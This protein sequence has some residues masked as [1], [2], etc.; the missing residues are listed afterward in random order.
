MHNQS[1]LIF[2][3][4]FSFI[5]SNTQ[6]LFFDGDD[7]ITVGDDSSLDLTTQ[8]T[9]SAWI[10]PST[11]TQETYA[12]I[13]AKSH[14]G[15]LGGDYEGLSY[16]LVW[17][18]GSNVIR[19]QISDGTSKSN[20]SM[21]LL[22]D[23]NW[24]HIAFTWDGSNLKI[25]LDGNLQSVTS[26][27]ISGAQATNYDLKIGG[28]AFGSD[29]GSNDDFKGNIDEVQI[30]NRALT[31]SEIID[32]M[33]VPSD[34]NENGLVGNWKFDYYDGYNPNLVYDY[35]QVNDGTKTGATYSNDTPCAV[36]N[37][38]DTGD[39]C[40]SLNVCQT[41]NWDYCINNDC[42]EGDG[43]CDGGQCPSGFTCGTDNCNYGNGIDSS[44]DCCICIDA[45]NNGFCDI[46]EDNCSSHSDC[47]EGQFC[48]YFGIC[49][50]LD[51]E[52]CHNNTCYEG[53]GDCDD[54][55]VGGTDSV[56]CADG[57]TCGIDNCDFGSDYSEYD[58]CCLDSNN[59]DICDEIECSSGFI[60]DGSSCSD[61]NECSNN[62]HN[63]SN[64][65]NC[66]NTSGSYQCQ[67]INECN[68]G[69][70][71]CGAN[72]F[73]TNT[74]GGFN[75]SCDPGY[76]GDGLSCHD[77][78]ECTD[79]NGND[80][81][82]CSNGYECANTS[83]SYACLD[84]NECENSPCGENYSCTNLDGSY[85][86]NYVG[87]G[88][89]DNE[90]PSTSDDCNNIC[91]ENDS[92]DGSDCDDICDIND[93]GSGPDC[94]GICE[95][96]DIAGSI[97]CDGICDN[98]SSSSVDCCEGNQYS[99][100]GES[101]C[102]TCGYG[103][104]TNYNNTFCFTCSA[105]YACD[106]VNMEIC[107]AG[108]FSDSGAM[109][110]TN[111]GSANKYSSEGSDSCLTCAAGNYTNWETAGTTTATECNEC[112]H[113]YNCPGDGYNYDCAGIIN[114]DGLYD[115]NNICCASGIFDCVGVCDGDESSN[116]NP[117]ITLIGDTV[118]E[119][120]VGELD[121][122][123]DPGALCNDSWDGDLTNTVTV[124][125]DIVNMNVADV[126]FVDYTCIDGCGGETNA[127]RVV[128]ITECDYS[129]DIDCDGI[130]NLLDLCFGNNAYGDTD[131]DGDCNDID[132]DDD[133]DGIDDSNDICLGQIN[134]DFDSDGICDDIDSDIDNDNVVNEIDICLG[135][136]LLGDMDNDGECDDIDEDDDGDGILDAQDNCT[137]DYS[138]CDSDGDGILDV[139]DPCYGN[140][141]DADFDQDGYCND[142]D[143]DDD[144]DTITDD[145]DIC[146]GYPNEDLDSDGICDSQDNDSDGDGVLDVDDICLGN[147][148][149]DF[150]QDGICD[151]IDDDDDD[152]NIL[153]EN[154]NCLG[155][156][157]LSIDYN[158]ICTVNCIQT[159][160]LLDHQFSEHY[161]I[162][163]D[164]ICN[165]LDTD[166][167]ND[168]LIDFQENTIV[169]DNGEIL[170]VFDEC[171]GNYEINYNQ[172]NQKIYNFEKGLT[173]NTNTWHNVDFDNDLICND[174]DFDSDNDGSEDPPYWGGNGWDDC[175]GTWDAAYTQETINQF[176]M[177][178]YHLNDI[179]DDG[180]CNDADNDDDNDGLIDFDYT[181]YQDPYNDKPDGT[182][183]TTSIGGFGFSPGVFYDNCLHLYIPGSGY[184]YEFPDLYVDFDNDGICDTWDIDS[185]G[186][187][188]IDEGGNF[189]N[190]SCFDLCLG[191]NNTLDYD[192][193]GLC[194]DT[195][196]DDDNDG[197]I[198]QNDS[199]ICGDDDTND[200]DSDGL[201]DN[202]DLDD[203][204]DGILDT[205]DSCLGFSNEDS[206]NDGIC[207]EEDNDSDGDGIPNNEDNCIGSPNVDFDEDGICDNIDDDDDNDGILDNQDLC[208]GDSS[209]SL[210]IYC[211]EN[212]G[213]LGNYLKE[214]DERQT[215]YLG[216]SY[217]Y[218]DG[219]VYRY[220]IDGD[221][222]CNDLDPDDDGDGLIDFE[223]NII[224]AE[225]QN[226]PPTG[227][228][229]SV[230]DKC[231]GNINNNF[232]A[233]IPHQTLCS[234][235]N[236]SDGGYLWSNV[237]F[238]ADGLCNDVDDDSDDDGVSDEN[239]DC[240][241]DNWASTQGY[242]SNTVLGLY[243]NQMSGAYYP[244]PDVDYDGLCNDLD[245]DNDNDGLI[246]FEENF[247]IDY[248]DLAS[249]CQHCDINNP[250][251]YFYLNCS[252]GICQQDLSLPSGV[253]GTYI[254]GCLNSP[255]TSADL[256]FNNLNPN[257]YSFFHDTNIDYDSDGVC[258]ID[259][260]DADGDEI[261]DYGDECFGDNSFFDYDFDDLC[262]DF[263]DDDDNDGILD[264]DDNIICGNSSDEAF[265]FDSDGVCDNWDLDDDDD[266]IFDTADSC[267]GFSN[268]D[269]DN[270]GICDDLDYNPSIISIEDIP[271]DQGGRV[272]VTFSSSSAD[273]ESLT[274]R[275]VEFYTIERLDSDSNDN[276][277]WVSVGTTSAYNQEQYVVEVTTLLNTIINQDGQVL[278]DGNTGFRVIASMEEG[279]FASDTGYGHSI[280]NIAPATPTNF[281]SN[282]E[283]G[284]I[285]LNWDE[286]VDNDFL[287]FDIYRN[288]EFLLSTTK[289]DIVDDALE[290]S[291]L[292]NYTVKSVDI[293]LNESDVSNNLQITTTG[294][295]DVNY[296]GNINVADVIEIV[297][298]II[299]QSLLTENQYNSADMN[300]DD[301]INIADI[302]FIIDII[303]DF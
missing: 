177:A 193:D 39:F 267:L 123:T 167:D 243:P 107:P 85:N 153:D 183:N 31:E 53:E 2:L 112:E 275:D 35:T 29:G 201:C 213:C 121:M 242:W 147:P 102:F 162:D 89:C 208:L 204:N 199:I 251:S 13:V 234:W 25:Y 151:N 235:N 224:L 27:T 155:D 184:W 114:G 218:Y 169:I 189:C 236:C 120:Y 72:A 165:N 216:E 124:S 4:L 115:H 65:Y 266:G 32:K 280:D 52:Y 173:P 17:R 249:G 118:V 269:S 291:T 300:N 30:W 105:G 231:I 8:G 196:N 64:G 87:N 138:E 283:D 18:Q 299:D 250:T 274:N 260:E 140:E 10:K 82:I 268:E 71:N 43:D 49:T 57:L 81:G 56:G 207:D 66:V 38:C 142:I 179:D 223:E 178:P 245:N 210:Y 222:I 212:Q 241:G 41:F 294:K 45:N 84:I 288:N 62:T 136:D 272:Y 302:V 129:V 47:Y 181:V 83:G 26:Q 46:D 170:I 252:G 227:E 34:A 264:E 9:I 133:N 137:G 6:S 221:G 220:D 203:D 277:L 158:N 88:I 163:G 33:I 104:Y 19:G 98:D 68:L 303:L 36:H 91:N 188:I 276:E 108:T 73:C 152:D 86:C 255:G 7:K 92:S 116:I 93:S 187:G 279:T 175:L 254:D 146:L 164:G 42:F 96:Q 74:N 54:G 195:D 130:A 292:Y 176:L 191:D 44:A 70:D 23:T 77:I 287:H 284:T 125:G 239:D 244:N 160:K 55:N 99:V 273:T 95:I 22:D 67:D 63:C 101:D 271:D 192:M 14:N 131:N 281:T 20:V 240:F 37:D 290:F 289:S 270:D 145:N 261:Y 111:C 110:C 106:G 59:N 51:G 15:N 219:Y 1:K 257:D 293:N 141:N 259:D 100:N 156:E 109:S 226:G 139:I 12:N 168:G 24:H 113:P 228:T 103:S 50:I 21:D 295:G 94:N 149:I 197:I 263:D 132:E 278:Q 143:T 180:I 233:Y 157:F 48:S 206:D 126:Y 172:S 117:T 79:T 282:F 159:L 214:G 148:N 60:W 182:Y 215:S 80:T 134:V 297:S 209:L 90:D 186:D 171:I 296:D 69:T 211:T 230:F 225:N 61:I 185:D 161:D 229:I 76:F 198:D 40:C 119:Y 58:C 232:K 75:C 253:G 237:D 3:L 286:P 265:D 217:T 248:T 301:K 154:D 128:V 135:D 200:Y 11:L 246:D 258:D 205:E 262:S 78:D 285:V 202:W 144:S 190:E 28:D 97:D 166:N 5:F 16:Y 122:Y 256:F 174:L 238:D 298:H 194:S 150:D 247:I 127:S